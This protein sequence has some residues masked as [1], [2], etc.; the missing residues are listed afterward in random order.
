M[1][2]NKVILY[3]VWVIVITLCTSFL[4]IFIPLNIV[5]RV[6]HNPVFNFL[7]I[8]VA[9]FFALDVI[10]SFWRAGKMIH[11]GLTEVNREKQNYIKR[12]LVLDLLSILPYDFIFG[13][14]FLG[15]LRLLK[16]FKVIG[17]LKKFRYYE[18]KYTTTITLVYFFFWLIHLAHW[19][20]CIWLVLTGADP[21]HNEY[22][23]YLLALY[24]SVTTLTTVG[25]GD[26][27]PQL[28]DNA[29]ILFS[30]IVQLTGVGVYGIV[31]GNIAGLI[32]KNDPAKAQYLDNLDKL[33]A[34]IRYRNLPKNLQGKLRDYFNYMW[35]NRYGYDENAFLLSLPENLQ[36]DV[37]IHL[38]KEIIEKIT[39]F[40]GCNEGFVHQISM[41]LEPEVITPNDLVFKYGDIGHAMYFLV[42]GEL[43]VLTQKGE[44]I[45]NIKE[46]DFF[47][48]I[49]L[50]MDTPRTATIKA[51]TYCDIYKLRKREFDKVISSYPKIGENIEK[52]V[53]ERRARYV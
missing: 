39:L 23:N 6:W 9:V 13:I 28:A 32:S 18:V 37:A 45:A 31:I 41:H 10:I 52:S 29:Q 47:G 17:I 25:Y 36:R 16:I 3:Q 20:S 40:A 8:C 22:S 12:W 43:E 48:E 7:N 11:P 21:N 19:I 15:L 33:K 1:Q 38:K 49:A 14:P 35:Q 27:T 42:K 24:W 2:V 50:F 30:I 5:F 46:G 53:R 26:I 34:L 44:I 4:A 51:T